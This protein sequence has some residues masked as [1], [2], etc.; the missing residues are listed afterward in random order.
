MYNEELQTICN[1]ILNG[2]EQYYV[3]GNSIIFKKVLCAFISCGHILFE[4]NPG[5][6]KTLLVKVFAK[7]TGCNWKRIQFTPDLMPADIVGTKVW[8]GG[9]SDFSIEK[10]PIFTNFILADEINRAMPKTQSALL[11]AMDESQ[12]TI[13]GNT[14]KLDE[15]FIVMATQNP[16]ENE[17]TY[18]LPEAQMDRFIM[19]LS[20]GYQETLEKE[21]EILKRRIMWRKDDPTSYIKSEISQNDLIRLQNEVENIYVDDNILKYIGEIIRKTRSNSRIKI[22]SS[23]RGGIAVLKLARAWAMIDGRDF[24]IPDDVKFMASDALS[25]RIILNFDSV[26]EEVRP[27][28]IISDIVNSIEVPK[29]YTK[30]E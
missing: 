3:S 15:P 28:K 4:D 8:R 7:I 20:L 24:V 30:A 29:N 12:V 6:G 17:G 19:K 26:L 5:L 16:I 27:E 13:E 25:H 21:C 18:P 2:A 22:G 10:G 11:E 14:Y 1:K 23:P 9:N